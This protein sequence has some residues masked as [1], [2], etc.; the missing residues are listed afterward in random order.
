MKYDE[1]K[2]IPMAIESIFEKG[3]SKNERL[4]QNEFGLNKSQN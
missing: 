1:M 3:E 2:M 4:E